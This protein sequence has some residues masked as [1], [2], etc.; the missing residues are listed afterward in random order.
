MNLPL[1]RLA[2]R[3]FGVFTRAQAAACGFSEYQIR[4]RLAAGEWQPVLG[5]ALG[6]PGLVVTP[7]VRDR[8]AQLS[9]PASILAGPSAARTWQIPV[10]DDTPCLYVG[11]HG[12][13]RLPGV[14]VLHE[15]PPPREVSL[16]QGL[17]TVGMALAVVDCLRLLAESPAVDL[18]DRA[19]QRGWISI[20]E[21]TARVD[22]RS[23]RRGRSRLLQL[24]D[25][26]RSGARSSAERRLSGLLRNAG[27]TGWMMNVEIRD[28]RGLVGIADVMFQQAQVIIEVDGL[29]YHTTPDQF[30]RDRTRQNRLVL[31]GWTV[32][33]FTWR[34]L[35]ERPDAVIATV[36]QAL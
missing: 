30:Q 14:R 25:G 20:E 32:L 13:T 3:Q 15:T 18:L 28:E 34:D 22:E 23:G 16:Y 12:R 26:V 27:L 17:P 31:A 35:N 29:A 8:A 36:R 21:F 5:R 6:L 1:H 10:P 2:R 33:R 11:R 4:R 24:L 9:L 19:L 7:L